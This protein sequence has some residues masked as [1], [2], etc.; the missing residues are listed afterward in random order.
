[1]NSF[2]SY[3]LH[4]LVDGLRV[5]E[6]YLKI[7]NYAEYL[8]DEFSIIN[9]RYINHSTILEDIIDQL[10]ILLQNPKD[11]VPLDKICR[12]LI[13]TNSEQNIRIDIIINKVKFYQNDII[14]KDILEWLLKQV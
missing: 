13:G 3:L 8:I 1:M 12:I 11:E 4:R 2:F 7:K 10:D 6:I 14:K 9:P 5:M